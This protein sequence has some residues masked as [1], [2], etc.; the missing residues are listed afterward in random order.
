MNSDLLSDWLEYIDSN[1][2]NE[3]DFGL[4]RLQDIYPKIL[5]KPIAKK[6]ILVGGTNG[7]GTTVEYLN[8]FFLTAGYK[9]GTYTSPHLIKFNERI[10]Q[11]ANQ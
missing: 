11:W 1:R 3:G 6:I 9:V 4:E 5:K 2:P 8:N 10:I 7:K